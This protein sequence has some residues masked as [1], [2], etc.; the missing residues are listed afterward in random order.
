MGQRTPRPPSLRTDAGGVTVVEVVLVVGLV[1]LLAF[2]ALVSVGGIH[3]RQS[4]SACKAELSRIRTAV[5]AF[6]ALPGKANPTASPPPSLATLKFI[7]LLDG[8]VGP[9]VVYSRVRS[10]GQWVARYTNGP[11]GNCAPG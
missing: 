7:G 5:E 6:R 10:N 3:S 8:N 11:K 9:Y 4:S 2:V 1:V